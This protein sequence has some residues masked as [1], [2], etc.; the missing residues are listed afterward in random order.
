MNTERRHELETNA[1]AQGITTWGDRLRPYVSAI[2]AIVAAL[3]ALYIVT[4][5]WNS[6][7]AARDREAWHE[8]ELALFDSDGEG[9][10]L[11]RLAN[12]EEF[13]GTVMQEWAYM[14]WADRQLRLAS[15][16]YLVD[17]DDAK[18]RLTSV[19]GIYE[20]FA[21][22]A[23]S[24]E[25]KNRARLGLARVSE[26][27]GDLAEA[28]AQYALVGGALA[29]LAEERIKQLEPKQ[30]SET[31]EWLSTVALPKRTPPS[32]PGVPG[33]RPGF[34]ATPPAADAASGLNFDSTQSLEE[35]LGGIQAG[36]QSKRYD[37]EVPASATDEDSADATPA[38]MQAADAADEAAPA[39][40]AEV[41]A[42]ES[43]AE[44]SIPG[45]AGAPQAAAE[46]ASEATAEKPADQ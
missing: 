36:E 38:E 30:A 3:L 18:K 24:S 37:G 13:E 43:P 6:Y 21:D 1:L 32:G 33:A 42:A 26:M 28:K 4:S 40:E 29:V 15:Q 20:Q 39:A 19:E 45:E 35:I 34:D 12:S 46:E 17:R 25:L 10:N 11:Q 16:R 23:S 22:N 9:R 44:E 2:L 5:L 41:P 7:Q 31:I 27:Q 8:F 14:A